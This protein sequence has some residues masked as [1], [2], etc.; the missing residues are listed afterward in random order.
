MG[1]KGCVERRE[2]MLRELR[3]LALKIRTKGKADGRGVR[4]VHRT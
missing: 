3:K 2:R 4:T 1:C